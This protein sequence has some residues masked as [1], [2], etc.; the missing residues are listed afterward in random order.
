M[1]FSSYL[2]TLRGTTFIRNAIFLLIISRPSQEPYSL[3]T[4]LLCHCQLIN[5]PL[6]VASSQQVSFHCC[7]FFSFWIWEYSKPKTIFCNTKASSY[8]RFWDLRDHCIC[9][10]G[11]NCA[12]EYRC[13]KV[14]IWNDNF[15]IFSCDT[16]SAYI[17]QFRK[18]STFKCPLNADPPPALLP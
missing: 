9:H 14:C 8:Q 13:C 4:L 18:K 5:I 3:L 16:S 7:S 11:I 15:E 12:R 17:K 1:L 6:H 10:S 2:L